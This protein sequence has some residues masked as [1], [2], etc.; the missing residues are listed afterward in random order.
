[1]GGRSHQWRPRHHQHVPS[2][3]WPLSG[4]RSY[5]HHPMRRRAHHWQHGRVSHI[6]Y[7][8]QTRAGGIVAAPCRRRSKEWSRK[9]KGVSFL[10]EMLLLFC[11][12]GSELTLLSTS[13]SGLSH[14]FVF[15]TT[16]VCLYHR[17][18][19]G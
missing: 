11:H 6:G 12:S 3:R 17:W 8:L 16:A 19:H 13:D 10:A 9:K 5:G 1:M 2:H 14:S 4:S 18:S 15:P 7:W